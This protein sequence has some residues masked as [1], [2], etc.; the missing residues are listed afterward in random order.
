MNSEKH[1][2]KS[3]QS[4]QLEK[5]SASRPCKKETR[6]SRITAR[7]RRPKAERSTRRKVLKTNHVKGSSDEFCELLQKNSMDVDEGEDEVLA[8]EQMRAKL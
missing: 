1:S 8:F 3:R 2:R 6:L 5:R 7:W 4:W